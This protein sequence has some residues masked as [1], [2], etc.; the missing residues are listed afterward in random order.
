[1]SISKCHIKVIY[2]IE[3]NINFTNTTKNRTKMALYTAWTSIEVCILQNHL[4]VYITQDMSGWLRHKG[5]NRAYAPVWVDTNANTTEK[6]VFCIKS[7][8][9]RKIPKYPHF[10]SAMLEICEASYQT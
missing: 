9:S 1:M 5:L 10:P 3:Q 4:T 8:F 7:I 6:K 2:D